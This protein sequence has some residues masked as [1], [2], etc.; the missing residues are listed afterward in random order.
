MNRNLKIR[1]KMAGRE[2]PTLTLLSKKERKAVK[3]HQVINRILFQL[4]LH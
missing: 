1:Y 4:Y 3:K 2:D